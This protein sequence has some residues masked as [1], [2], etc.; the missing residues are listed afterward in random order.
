M[1]TEE[2]SYAGLY[3]DLPDFDFPFLIYL[4]ESDYG[5][6]E[7]HDVESKDKGQKDAQAS[8]WASYSAKMKSEDTKK[9]EIRLK[10]T[11]TVTF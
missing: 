6:H 10:K 5:N 7:D 3:Y 2:G 4:E 8:G 1:K 9:E 11:K